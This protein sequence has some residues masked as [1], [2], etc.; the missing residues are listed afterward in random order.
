M[1]ED[2]QLDN[3][4]EEVLNHVSVPVYGKMINYRE[5]QKRY[6]KATSNWV[7]N[8]VL[9]Y[10]NKEA[11]SIDDFRKKID[12]DN[13]VE[14][15][16]ISEFYSYVVPFSKCKEI[17]ATMVETNKSPWEIITDLGLL[18]NNNL[19][20][21]SIVLEAINNNPAQLEKYKKGNLNSK[22]FFIGD[23][24]KNYRN[25]VNPKELGEV[26]DNVLKEL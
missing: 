20:I 12:E 13:F 5:Y 26:L 4:L 19:D 11:I 1:S 18:E 3:F 16:K 7:I 6:Y 22:N 9:S 8:V 21:K 2:N 17:F 15:I 24:M 10:L 14:I 23:I 25:K